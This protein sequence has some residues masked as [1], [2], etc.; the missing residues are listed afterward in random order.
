MKNRWYS[1]FNLKG[2]YDGPEKEFVNAEN[3]EW[4]K[5]FQR[6]FEEIKNEFYQF[7]NSKDLSPYFNTKMV[8]SDNDWRTIALKNWSVELYKNQVYF[9]VTTK[10]LN[11]YPEIISASFNLLEPKSIIKPH[12]GDTN[13]IYRCHLGLTVPEGLPKCGFQVMGEKRPWVENEWLIFMDAYEHTA[14][15]HSENQRVI[16]L[17][18]VIR[19]EF[20][21]YKRE[22]ISTVRTSLF[23]QKRAMKF[24]FLNKENQKL[25]SFLVVA[26]RPFVYIAIKISNFF[27]IF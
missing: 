19:S 10:L 7:F 11:K 17:L 8:K 9:P 3:F 27:R 26:M 20:S 5:E 12:V 15:N 1:I 16:F 4:A 21:P 6:H 23:L 25:I 2:H 22:V 14:F 13:A 24:R 18:D